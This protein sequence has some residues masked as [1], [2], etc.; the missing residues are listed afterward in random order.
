MEL[1]VCLPEGISI[2]LKAVPAAPHDLLH[3]GI[4]RADRRRE[5]RPGPAVPLMRDGV[6]ETFPP[7]SDRIGWQQGPRG[8]RGTRAASSAGARAGTLGVF[9]IGGRLV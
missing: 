4:M 3:R 2:G 5:H 1:P 9:G 7:A 6:G 8:R